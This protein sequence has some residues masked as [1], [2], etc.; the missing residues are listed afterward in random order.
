MDKQQQSYYVTRMSTDIM[1][2]KR[3]ADVRRVVRHAKVV[4]LTRGEITWAGFRQIEAWAD[5]KS[6]ML[7]D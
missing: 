5:Q 2:A 4:L 6:A 7:R 1:H 3:R